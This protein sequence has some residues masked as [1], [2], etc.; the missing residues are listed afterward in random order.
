MRKLKLPGRGGKQPH[1]DQNDMELIRKVGIDEIRDQV[2]TVVE[3]KL[4]EPDADPKIP[5][6]GSP[7]YKAMHACKA[8]SRDKLFMSHRI[9]PDHE[10]TEAQMESVADMLVRWIVREYNF[11]Q[12]EEEKMKERHMRLADFFME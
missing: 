6:A 3:D 10:L 1:L 4:K 5:A 12:E 8:S 2:R 7:V 9:H 11:F